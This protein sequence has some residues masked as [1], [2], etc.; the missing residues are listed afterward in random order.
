MS[1]FSNRLAIVFILF[2]LISITLGAC[3][4]SSSDDTD[5]SVGLLWDY[6]PGSLGPSN[7]AS[8][9]A[10]FA[11]CGSGRQQSPIDILDDP[12]D[13]AP[14]WQFDW[15]SSTLRMTNDARNIIVLYDPGSSIN[16]SGIEYELK[17]LH[18]H[19]PSE[20]YY[21]GNP[22]DGEIHFVHESAAGNFAIVAVWITE[23]AENKDFSII[24]SNM[25]IVDDE[26]IDDPS[27]FVRALNFLP[28]SGDYFRY[29]G[30]LSE[31]PCTESVTWIVLRESIELSSN[32]LQ[33][34]ENVLGENI[35]PLQ[36][37]NGRVIVQQ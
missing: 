24:L 14:D 37:L 11:L 7:W 32:Q 27:K 28:V 6:G 10:D 17:S 19:V 23:G 13:D 18:L 5:D 36:P 25:P 20:H 8:L 33:S 31:P 2:V 26:N 22:F 9:S 34:F 35:R 12:I 3:S 1:F 21:Q 30:S 16:V 15:G 4:S 29:D